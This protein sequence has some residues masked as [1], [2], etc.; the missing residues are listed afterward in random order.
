MH[1]CIVRRRHTRVGATI[2]SGSGCGCW[3]VAMGCA[4]TPSAW[5]RPNTTSPSPRSLEDAHTVGG[6]MQHATRK[7]VDTRAR[8]LGRARDIIESWRIKWGA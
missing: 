2:P 8:K 7:A 4:A 3:G 6:N 1:L 5:A